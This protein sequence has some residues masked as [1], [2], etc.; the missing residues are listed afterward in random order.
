[1]PISILFNWRNST[2]ISASVSIQDPKA[3][4][5]SNHFEM[6]RRSLFAASRHLRRAL[7]HHH[8]QQIAMLAPGS[9]P[10]SLDYIPKPADD[11][12]RNCTTS[13]NE[14][15]MFEW[16]LVQQDSNLAS[17]LPIVRLLALDHASL[18]QVLFNLIACSSS[19]IGGMTCVCGPN[20]DAAKTQK[21]NYNQCHH[22]TVV[23]RSL[24]NVVYRH[25]M[26]WSH[27]NMCSHWLMLC[28]AASGTWSWEC[29][30]LFAAAR[31]LQCEVTACWC[32]FWAIALEFGFWSF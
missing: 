21:R 30:R 4:H 32:S 28:F 31:I 6:Y 7:L 11:K 26:S 5:E 29:Q 13:G 14:P 15:E 27:R 17:D 3:S 16:C 19:V 24:Y 18:K 23:Y 8:G 2:S 20:W 22:V 12:G 10:W 1:M 9:W 25:G